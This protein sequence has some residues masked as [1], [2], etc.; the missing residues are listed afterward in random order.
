MRALLDLEVRFDRGRAAPN[1]PRTL[2]LDLIAHGRTIVS[3]PEL[4]VPHPRAH[5]RRFV[6]GPL[7]EVA[8]AWVHPQ[9]ARSAEDLARTATIGVDAAP[10]EP[11]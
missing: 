8:P 10:I 9:L 6:M 3:T 5:L 7:S 1:S 2:D 11:S 4:I